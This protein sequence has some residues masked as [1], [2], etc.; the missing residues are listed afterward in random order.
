LIMALIAIISSVVIFRSISLS[1]VN[2]PINQDIVRHGDFVLE[3]TATG[4]LTASRSID[5]TAPISNDPHFFKIARF[6]PE[7]SHIQAGETLMELDSQEVTQKLLEYRAE[8][9]KSEEDLRKRALE[10]NSRLSDLHVQLEQARTRLG[11]ARLKLDVPAE[12]ISQQQ[13]KQDRLELAQAEAES[14]LLQEKNAALERMSKA[15]LLVLE[16][17]IANTRL[18]MAQAETLQKA[19]IVKAPIAGTVLYKVLANG[20]K[21][22]VGELTCHHEIVLQIPDLSTLRLEAM[23]EE[24]VAG[25]IRVGQPV[26]IKLDA[27]ADENLTGKIVSVGSVLRAKRWDIPIKVIDVI[28][29]LDQKIER[30]TAGMTAIGQ[31]EVERISNLLLVPMRAVQENN[32][33]ISVRVIDINGKITERPISVGRRNQQFI[34]VL[35]GLHE[36]ERVVI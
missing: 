22:K 15:E 23:V 9:E 14:K 31:I 21:R 24:D 4:T 20:E 28:I 3:V 25:R 17:N 29:E 27:V 16:N 7:G 34:E 30:M 10:Y 1:N 2:I 26:R 5:I 12:L 33:Y 35:S 6:A 11:I 18:R 32:G 19:C 8:L 13:L 36:G